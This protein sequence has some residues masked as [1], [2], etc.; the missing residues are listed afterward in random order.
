MC[1]SIAHHPEKTSHSCRPDTGPL[2]AFFNVCPGPR[3]GKGSRTNVASAQHFVQKRSNFK[4]F[5]NS[6]RRVIPTQA[7]TADLPLSS[8][9]QR[10]NA[11]TCAAALQTLDEACDEKLAHTH[12]QPS[13]EAGLDRAQTVRLLT[14]PQKAQQ[15]HKHTLEDLQTNV[16]WSS[17]IEYTSVYFTSPAT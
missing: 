3:A 11:T 7:E 4:P 9:R 5:T 2:P 15:P 14:Y 12:L 16:S 1:H 17:N 10:H 8:Q 13:F 6:G